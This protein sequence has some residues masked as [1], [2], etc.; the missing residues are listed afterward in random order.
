M[1]S[2][3]ETDMGPLAWLLD[4]ISDNL[5]SARTALKRA[6]QQQDDGVLGSAQAEKTGLRTARTQVHQAAGAIELLGFFGAARLMQAAE[7]ALDRLIDHPEKLDAAA[8]QRFDAGFNAL[9]DFL[10]AQRA[11]KNEP[12]L[13]LYPQYR[14][15]MELA[16]AER[17]H[18]ADL[19]DY[20][21]TWP[22]A[23]STA[24]G[25][26][27]SPEDRAQFEMGLLHVLRG[28]QTAQAMQTLDAVAQRAQGSSQGPT[29]S[30]WWLA[31]GLFEAIERGLLTPDL[32]IKRLLNRLNLQLR[33][34]LQ[35][36]SP[37]PQRLGHDLTFFCA[38]ALHGSGDITAQTLPVLRVIDNRLHLAAA[39]FADYHQSHFGLID[40]ALVQQVRK[41]VQTLRD[42]WSAL[43]G[44][45]QTPLDTTR[46]GRLTELAQ[47][48]SQP[49]HTLAPGS[50]VLPQA[51][52]ALFKKIGA[53]ADFLT[54]ERA[55][56]VATAILF[57][58]ITFAHFRPEE[59]RFLERSQILAHR[60][61][62]SADG[63]TPDPLAG[64]ME[65]LFRQAS[66][67]QTMGSVVQELRADM[68]T[69]E[70]L[71]DAYFR[72]P[73][74]K[75]DLAQVPHL[76]AQMRGVF[77]VLGLDVA[78]HALS[79][80]RTEIDSLVAEDAL[81]DSRRFDAL[82][83]N[84]GVLGFLVD[85]LSYQPE[86][87][88]TLFVFD[89]DKKELRAVVPSTRRTAPPTLQQDVEHA[90]QQLKDD[91]AQ[92][93]SADETQ[94]RL[95]Q[96]RAEAALAGVP[97]MPAQ[98]LQ[99][100][101]PEPQPP[102][103][104]ADTLPPM[105]GEAMAEPLS[106]APVETAAPAA[107]APSDD[108]EQQELIDIFLEEA[109][110][111]I[112]NGHEQVQQ[113]HAHL[114]DEGA[115]ASLRRAFHTLKGSSRMVG[116]R[117][118]GEAA[119]ALEQV[120]NQQI[121]DQHR[122]S[123]ELL[124][125]AEQALTQL[126]HWTEAI[127][128]GS[129]GPFTSDALRQ[130]ADAFAAGDAVDMPQTATAELPAQ[131]AEAPAETP[132]GPLP[133][134][135]DLPVEAPTAETA[136]H[137]AEAGPNFT[138][139]PDH[140]FLSSTGPEAATPGASEVPPPSQ[141]VD[142]EPTLHHEPTDFNALFE[143]IDLE[144]PAPDSELVP[145]AAASAGPASAPAD[146]DLAD[147]LAPDET[148]TTEEDEPG[149]RQ[150]GDLRIPTPLYNIYLAEADEL[151]R[152]LHSEIHAW[153]TDPALSLGDAAVIAAHKLAGSSAT[154]GL[155]SVAELASQTEHALDALL[156]QPADTARPADLD[157]LAQASSDIKQLLHQFAAG[158]LKPVQSELLARLDALREAALAR[159][160]PSADAAA[161]ASTIP[162]PDFAAEAAIAP[163]PL[164][165]APSWEA[166]PTWTPEP[167]AT[168][169]P[170]SQPE[171]AAPSFT[172]A[173]DQL[174]D[175]IDPDLFPIFEEEAN[176]LL[177]AL[178]ASLRQWEQ[179]PMDPAPA[180]QAMR[181]LHTLKGSARMA[182]AMQLGDLAHSLESDIDSLTANAPVSEAD[183]TELLGRFD[184][185]NTRFDRLC[186]AAQRG[187]S[188]LSDAPAASQ[189]E[190]FTPSSGAEAP[191]AATAM[192]ETSPPV[193][194]EPAARVLAPRI[195]AQAVRVRA[196]LLDRL[197]NQAG[198][199]TISRA[200]LENEIAAI[201]TSVGD[202]SDNLERLRQ[203]VREIEIQAEAQMTAQVQAARDEN[204]DFD[205]LEF[206]RFTRAQELTRM[207]AESV[208]DIAMVQGTL[209][210]LLREVDDDMTRQARQTR[211]LQRDLLRTRMVEFDSLSERLYRTVRQAAKDLNKAVRLEI[212]GGTIELDRGVLERVSGSFD[213]L[214]RNAVAHG[215]ETAEERQAEGKPP[216]GTITL[217]LRQDGNEVVITLAD[218]GRGLNYTAIRAKAEQLGLVAPDQPF[219][220][221]DLAQL[222]FR[223]HFSSAES[224]TAVAG[225]GVGL[226]VVRTEV[227]AL[228]GRVLL[229]NQPGAGARFTLL[230][231][232]TTAIT[233]VV[234]L[235]T[236]SAL[237]AVPANL[238]DI[239]LRFKP[240]QI[241]SAARS[242][243]IDYADSTLPFY[244]L[245][246][247]LGQSGASG[248]PLGKSVPVVVIRSATQRVAI[249]V[250]EVVGNRE[251]VVKN[252]GPQLAR[253]PG[254]AG[255][256]VLPNGDAALIYNPV[257]LASV[258]GASAAEQM[259]AA[260]LAPASRTAASEPVP[261]ISDQRAGTPP[262]AAAPGAAPLIMVVDDSITV[263]RVTQ[264]FLAR[265]GY[266]VQLAKDGLDALE[267]LQ[268]TTSLPDVILLDIEMPRMDGFDLTRNIRADARLHKLPIIMITS[269]IADKHRNYAA[270]LGVNHYLG[271]PY[272]ET[273]LLDLIQTF[274]AS[275]ASSQT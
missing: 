224:T 14:D 227:N 74:Q 114:E 208:N 109:R 271:K 193:A 268:Q 151:S 246:A 60:L 105:S 87:A 248:E 256:S 165:T 55:L 182:G 254:L 101:S 140:L 212:V 203:Q 185:L 37:A 91:I 167:I 226:D 266:L 194:A 220:D 115:L 70:K 122:A 10:E 38:Q 19:W 106:A 219:S 81:P 9:V 176:E 241:A 244:W 94:Q 29:A 216:V 234:L 92:G 162:E 134:L 233:H 43:A 90:A 110:E 209:G 225:R 22:D 249:Q 113:L 163:T 89:D 36:Q 272:S 102:S 173:P 71:L 78:S 45:A 100:A 104:E 118:Y 123:P 54:P 51:L 130:A 103:L 221:E 147:D 107:P 204:R 126:G 6:A 25:A 145:P 236:G 24:H 261:S 23:P 111:V 98:L 242:L 223:P 5:Q 229:D 206:D 148:A 270:Q 189:S 56:D 72:D 199:I 168:S 180:A 267:Q 50:E 202:L 3:P 240:E 155:R 133:T 16:Q 64:W 188:Q 88:K 42:A 66:E 156:D 211:E 149:Y 76:L 61:G 96:L 75:P 192:H 169:E 190:V 62:Q 2:A 18:P 158:F 237:Y 21:W 41:R 26:A 232:L 150:I 7:N 44:H 1:A 15:L 59:Q 181:A 95:A 73:S 196:G 253:V 201:R 153:L 82:A 231:P 230:L 67:T 243:S 157:A 186:G 124:V 198:E 166:P 85:M 195:A 152:H 17:I 63:L 32:D 121:A 245:G 84:I 143:G 274:T 47:A 172:S 135:F 86:L 39:P 116:L 112:G 200:R 161:P 138:D 97:D 40:P 142:D 263:R 83:S 139:L 177:P 218:D 205:P 99:A 129:A 137:P 175:S 179:H 8:L 171:A 183:L 30:L 48:L 255:I 34:Q 222:V 33:S 11:G 187:E 13:K 65:D 144:L 49:L 269:R 260:L 136:P 207:M 132:F 247:L 178:A 214:L 258:Y 12:A 250:D 53:Q 238:V 127:Q 251:V 170:A 146:A 275:G 77:S 20:D 57:L 262:A 184:H 252:L 228:G 174:I 108:D 120:F 119:W 125:L 213:H 52:S 46:I 235:R 259:Q 215:I 141:L 4:Q 191:A 93:L 79:Y 257:A 117:D 27:L 159:G 265:N 217:T 131:T 31:R 128:Q 69:V 264:R 210:R 273:E 35:G 68:N 239:V 28:Q 58:E 160:N 154:V 80:L 197:V 164:T